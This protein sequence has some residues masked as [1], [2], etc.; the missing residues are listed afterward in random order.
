MILGKIGASLVIS[1]VLSSVLT[2]AAAAGITVYALASRSSIDLG[3]IYAVSVG[4]GGAFEVTLGAG[5]LL[6]FA[7]IVAAMSAVISLVQIRALGGDPG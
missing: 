4:K 3:N 5:L 2:M 6:T 7:L 1:T